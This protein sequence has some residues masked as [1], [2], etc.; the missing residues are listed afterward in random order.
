VAASSLWCKSGFTERK[1]IC[2]SQESHSVCNPEPEV[3]P[4]YDSLPAAERV[5]RLH[6][7]NHLAWGSLDEISPDLREIAALSL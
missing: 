3:L 2:N 1:R 4:T 7:A 6:E 5:A